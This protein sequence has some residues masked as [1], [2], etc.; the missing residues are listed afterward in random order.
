MLKETMT[1]ED[2]NG[3]ERTEDFYF[4]LTEAEVTEMQLSTN[5]G[6][7]EMIQKIIKAK[8]IPAIISIF[9]DILLKAYGEKS[10]DGKYFKK[11]KELSE[12]FSQTQAYSDL[13][14][15]LA[16]DADAASA[17]INGL[18]PK[19]MAEEANKNKV[20]VPNEN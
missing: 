3:E 13:Y 19:K 1:Y 12:A 16:T 5:G 18:L 4:N 7:A 20:I 11:S 17:F 15:K 14:M 9:K 8:D 10:A 2:F 6:L